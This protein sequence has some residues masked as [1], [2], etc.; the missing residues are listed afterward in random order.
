M[1]FTMLLSLLLVLPALINAEE[2]VSGDSFK[3]LGTNNPVTVYKVFEP[4]MFKCCTTNEEEHG[5]VVVEQTYENDKLVSSSVAGCMHGDAENINVPSTHTPWIMDVDADE[6]T[7]NSSLFVG[8]IYANERQKK[9]D[10]HA[11]SRNKRYRYQVIFD[12]SN[13]T[14]LAYE[15][16]STLVTPNK[17]PIRIHLSVET[18]DTMRFTDSARANTNRISGC[19]K[20]FDSMQNGDVK[21]DLSN[22]LLSA[23]E[24]NIRMVHTDTGPPLDYHTTIKSH[25]QMYHSLVHGSSS[26]LVEVQ[27]TNDTTM[28]P[29][30]G[31]RSR[32]K[33]VEW[34]RDFVMMSILS[35]MAVRRIME[36]TQYN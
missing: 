19:F 17:N 29:S 28:G 12:L 35:M 9:V 33:S 22:F 10:V 26:A 6:L 1:A 36:R 13:K 18:M 21:E 2:D 34:I 16:K 20:P 3:D 25:D 27:Y 14:R 5:I 32:N 23:N 8:I 31:A 15:P 11:V 7:F 4:S 30:N 24:S